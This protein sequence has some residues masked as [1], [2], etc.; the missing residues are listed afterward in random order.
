MQVL[1]V[2]LVQAALVGCQGE[3]DYKDQLAQWD[4]QVP[5]EQELQVLQDNQGHLVLMG[6]VVPLEHRVHQ[7][8]LAL[9]VQQ[10]PVVQL[11]QTEI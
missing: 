2:P 9:R 1:Q 3:M 8:L 7:V 4:H 10:E 11:A 5:Q 6:P